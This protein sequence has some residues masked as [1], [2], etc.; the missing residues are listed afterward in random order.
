MRCEPFESVHKPFPLEKETT[1]RSGIAEGV[2]DAL[3][4]RAPAIMKPNRPSQSHLAPPTGRSISLS[5][6]TKVGAN[7]CLAPSAAAASDAL[8]NISRR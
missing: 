5:R 4:V 3:G 8:T 7:E 6:G 2:L 1:D